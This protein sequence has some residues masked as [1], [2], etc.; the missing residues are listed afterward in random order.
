[1]QT[2]L[3][4][5]WVAWVRCGDEPSGQWTEELRRELQPK[6]NGMP[7]TKGLAHEIQV[8]RDLP[9]ARDLVSQ[10]LIKA[11]LL[12]LVVHF[13][14]VKG[15]VPFKAGPFHLQCGDGTSQG[16][17]FVLRGHLR[18]LA[19]V[20]LIPLAANVVNKQSR[21]VVDGVATFHSFALV[22]VLICP[23]HGICT[24]AVALR[25]VFHRRHE[26]AEI[27]LLFEAAV[28]AACVL[29]HLERICWL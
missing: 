28:H 17:P 12:G 16:H 4:G 19:K 15:P 2:M 27:H 25:L 7:G 26:L 14:Q 1:M 20:L 11:R 5:L 10:G 23:G 21:D 22:D 6:D 18:V 9:R 29:R 24:A 3:R 13:V 8:H